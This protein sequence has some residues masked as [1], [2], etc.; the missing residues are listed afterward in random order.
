MRP[1]ITAAT[2]FPPLISE[3]KMDL[4]NIILQGV[5]VGGL[6][7]LFAAG[8]LGAVALQSCAPTRCDSR[9]DLKP[10]THSRPTSIR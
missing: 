4:I 1:K 6:Y 10:L 9:I 5:L 3:P 7:A 2:R 8:L